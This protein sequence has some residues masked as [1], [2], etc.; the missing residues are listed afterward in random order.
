MKMTWSTTT[1]TTKP[2][3]TMTTTTTTTTTTTRT[4]MTMRRQTLPMSTT[5]TILK[6]WA[7]RCHQDCQGH[8]YDHRDP[9][10]APE[11]WQLLPSLL[12]R[13]T[14]RTTTTTRRRLGLVVAAV[15]VTDDPADWTGP[16]LP[17]AAAA[18]RRVGWRAIPA[19]RQTLRT[20]SCSAQ[21]GCCA[22][23]DCDCECRRRPARETARQRQRGSA[24][25]D[26]AGGA[27][28]GPI[29][30]TTGV[31]SAGNSTPRRIL[32]AQLP[33]DPPPPV[34]P[35][36]VPPMPHRCATA[37]RAGPRSRAATMKLQ[38]RRRRS[39][40]HR[41]SAPSSRSCSATTTAWWSPVET[42]ARSPESV[43]RA[44]PS[45]S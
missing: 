8:R 5:M 34:P 2:M 23:A 17:D 33:Q 20:V 9:C 43:R 35:M 38:C 7:A 15:R 25:G 27:A 16:P 6:S 19:G 4:M 10:H 13:C 14:P 41:A 44:E 3:T 31:T 30:E 36:P 28:R 11:M 37:H 40:G 26:A 1:L 45:R 24:T 29:L 12:R 32:Q 21:R 42:T 22:R 39:L 18:A